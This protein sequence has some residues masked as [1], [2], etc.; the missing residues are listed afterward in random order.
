MQFSTNGNIIPW[1]IRTHVKPTALSHVREKVSLEKVLVGAVTTSTNSCSGWRH[2]QTSFVFTF[3][4]RGR[5]IFRLDAFNHVVHG[6]QTIRR[7]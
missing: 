3:T 5:T 1:N 7:S 6:V 4:A 2:N